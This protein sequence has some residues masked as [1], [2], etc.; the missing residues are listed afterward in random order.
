MRGVGFLGLV[1]G[2]CGVTL[3][4]GQ[5]VDWPPFAYKNSTTNE[6]MGLG[7]DI[8]DGMSLGW[9]LLPFPSKCN[10][11]LRPSGA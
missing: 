6:L 2:A 1:G 11:V 4:F 9:I 8:A 10:T 3:K 7:K 5:D